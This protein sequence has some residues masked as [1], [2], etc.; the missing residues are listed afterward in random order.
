MKTVL[1]PIDF[2]DASENALNYA[3]EFAKANHAKIILLHVYDYSIMTVEPQVLMPSTR[4]LL[5]G[6]LEH[7]ENIRA[8]VR[9]QYGEQLAIEC[10]CEAGWVIDTMN[11]FA[12]DHRVDLIIL[13]MQGGGYVSEKIVGSTA[14][15]LMRKAVCPV[16]G[17]AKQV[18]FKSV[19]RIV[20]ASDNQ[21]ADYNEM[22][23]PLRALIRSFDAHLYVLHVREPQESG[24]Q[25][26][27]IDPGLERALDGIS[28]TFHSL[29]HVD[30]SE[31][32]NQFI[33]NHAIDLVVMIPR[34]HSFFHSL[35]HE[36]NTKKIAFHA[37]IPLL[38]LP[39]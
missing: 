6:H 14:T 37:N 24:D 11:A 22:L 20:L 3:A 28:Y 17:I 30:V 1:V 10:Y 33:S 34:K 12:E 38:T 27:V 8:R 9:K 29:F 13:G 18:K 36:A 25:E 32:I 26:D 19:K 21:E 4:E 23:R 7:L 39:E 31:G 16:I 5:D 2:S 35:L 15:S